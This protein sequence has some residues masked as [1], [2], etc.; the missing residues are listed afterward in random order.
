MTIHCNEKQDPRVFSLAALL[1]RVIS[2][3]LSGHQ[4][5]AIKML[6]AAGFFVV[7]WHKCTNE[8]SITWNRCFNGEPANLEAVGEVSTFN[9]GGDES[10]MHTIQLTTALN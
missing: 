4:T 3:G 7:K 9:R 1:K 6:L 10:V 5:R 8:G 2:V